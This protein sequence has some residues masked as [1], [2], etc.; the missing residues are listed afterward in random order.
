MATVIR[1]RRP[2]PRAAAVIASF[3]VHAGLAVLFAWRLSH[4]PVVAEPPVMSV[5]ILPWPSRVAPNRPQA[6]PPPGR[7]GQPDQRTPRPLAVRPSAAPPPE[8]AVP[9]PAPFAAGDEPGGVALRGLLDCRPSNLHRLAAEARARCDQRLAGDPGLRK[10]GAGG[11]RLHL[12]PSGRFAQ[13][14]EAYL[15][16]RPKKGCKVRAGGDA[17]AMGHQG[18]AGGITCVIPF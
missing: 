5:E 16:R 11:P 1:I 15:A 8:A 12:D 3:A 14:D 4:G 18:P 9:A 7:N 2:G 6:P 13:D 10:T 17:D